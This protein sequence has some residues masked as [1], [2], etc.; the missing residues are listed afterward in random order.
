MKKVLFCMVLILSYLNAHPVSYTIDLEVS[1]DENTKK[2]KIICSSNSK[3]KC[4][5]HSFHLL[6]ENGNIIITKRFP[7]LKK[8]ALVSLENKPNK[9]I[10]FLRKV[11]E[12]TY[13]KIF[14]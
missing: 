10:F 14:E 3:N 13:N 6:D 4:G 7:F 8:H 1:Y 12:H 2:A 5:L 11:P 9:M